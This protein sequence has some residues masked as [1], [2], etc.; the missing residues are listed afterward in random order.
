MKTLTLTTQER[1]QPYLTQV[2]ALL[3]ESYADVCGGLHF[4]SPAQLLAS[5]SRWRMVLH[6]GRVIAVDLFKAKKGWKLVAM[7][8]CTRVGK[9]AKYA[10][11]RLIEADLPRCWMEL[12]EKAE[13]FVM[14]YCGGHRY[15]IHSS[16]VPSLLDK[17]VEL[18]PGDGYHYMR[19]I[20]GIT[21][22]KVA[23]ARHSL[24]AGSLG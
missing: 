14:T 13:R 12:S 24:P 18:A 16:L 17:N 10:L 20:L 19:P 8:T 23:G 3:V 2:W 21:K 15:L 6:H 7:A 1:M 11:R 22:T 9:R 4:D 5:T